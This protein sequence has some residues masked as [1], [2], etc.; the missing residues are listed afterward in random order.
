[1]SSLLINKNHDYDDD[2]SDAPV[3]EVSMTLV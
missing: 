1:M 2:G 3:E